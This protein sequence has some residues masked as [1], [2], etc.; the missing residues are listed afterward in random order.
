MNQFQGTTISA[1]IGRPDQQ[2]W[3]SR[4]ELDRGTCELPRLILH[5]LQNN[6]GA[7]WWAESIYKII[8]VIP[9]EP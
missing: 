3:G 1:V 7:S 8:Q 6:H 2:I 4:W 9:E 5:R